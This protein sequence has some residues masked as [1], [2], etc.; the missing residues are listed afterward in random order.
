MCYYI[1]PEKNVTF[2]L[3]CSGQLCREEHLKPARISCRLRTGTPRPICPSPGLAGAHLSCTGGL[4][5]H[6]SSDLGNTFL[7]IFLGI[8]D[9]YLPISRCQKRT[10]RWS[11]TSNCAPFSPC[12]KGLDVLQHQLLSGPTTLPSFCPA[13]VPPLCLSFT[14]LEKN[15]KKPPRLNKASCVDCSLP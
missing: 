2:I 9:P 13:A 8:C 5:P 10:E 12:A 1:I 11:R 3:A 7:L 6:C 15:N 14:L 4:K